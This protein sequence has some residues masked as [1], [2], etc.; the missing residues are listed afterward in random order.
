LSPKAKNVFGNERETC[1]DEDALLMLV[2]TQCDELIN[3]NFSSCRDYELAGSLKG[4]LV[5]IMYLL[6][7]TLETI[8]EKLR[9]VEKP[10]P[11]QQNIQTLTRIV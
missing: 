3:S 2:K 5:L 11:R 9:V 7:K 1:I 10:V 8:F 4:N 6:D